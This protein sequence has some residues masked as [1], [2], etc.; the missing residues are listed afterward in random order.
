MTSLYDSLIFDFI[1]DVEAQLAITFR[2]INVKTITGFA[3]LY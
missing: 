1:L 2:Y 3:K